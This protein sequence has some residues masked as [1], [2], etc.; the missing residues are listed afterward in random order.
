M[1]D[2]KPDRLVIGLAYQAGPD[3]RIQR[4]SDGGRDYFTPRQ[5]ELASRSFMKTSGGQIGLNHFD[6]TLGHAEVA[7]SYIYRNPSPWVV[8]G[9]EVAKQG[10]WVLE[11]VLDPPTWE[12]ALK[13]EI[14]GWSPQG[15]AIRRT[16][17]A[18]Q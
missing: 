7:A 14:T 3:P 12:M 6:G 2:Q 11:A 4:G 10:D 13:G 9:V 16:R 8:D 1:S 5:L 17:S 18:Q 15:S